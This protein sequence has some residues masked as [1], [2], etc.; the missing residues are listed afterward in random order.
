MIDSMKRLAIYLL[1]IYGILSLLLTILVNNQTLYLPIDIMAVSVGGYIFSVFNPLPI[2]YWGALIL[3]HGPS[4]WINSSTLTAIFFV[5]PIVVLGIGL[6]LFIKYQL[7]REKRNSRQVH[8]PR[9][10]SSTEK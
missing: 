6:V 10:I 4:V 5:Y 7:D 3:Q 8:G 2:L 9:A 1:L